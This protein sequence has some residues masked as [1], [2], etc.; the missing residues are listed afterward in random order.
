M[1]IVIL[2]SLVVVAK[3]RWSTIL[4][5]VS[6]FFNV[7]FLWQDFGSRDMVLAA[8]HNVWAIFVS[9]MFLTV[10]IVVMIG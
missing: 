7:D 6:Y 4:D 10:I 9:R 2:R 1:N 5:I 8:Q 3:S